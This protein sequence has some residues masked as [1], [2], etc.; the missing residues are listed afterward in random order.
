MNSQIEQL[1]ECNGELSTAKKSTLSG[2]NSFTRGCVLLRSARV[3]RP[4]QAKRDCE[5]GRGQIRLAWSPRLLARSSGVRAAHRAAR[6]WRRQAHA[7]GFTSQMLLQCG[8]Q[9]PRYVQFDS[10]HRSGPRN[11]EYHAQGRSHLRAREAPL[12]LA[13]FGRYLSTLLR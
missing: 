8:T 2:S 5:S 10:G 12:D 3:V 4:V 11:V 1:L 9:S 7:L 13:I 6:S